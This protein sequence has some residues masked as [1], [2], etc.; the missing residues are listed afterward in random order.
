M[1]PADVVMPLFAVAVPLLP[2]APLSDEAPPRSR[3]G[4][5]RADEGRKL[6]AITG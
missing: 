6:A 1:S 3:R 4:R 2:A 5:R